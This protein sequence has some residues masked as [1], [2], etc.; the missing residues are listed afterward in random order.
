MPGQLSRLFT[1]WFLFAEQK[2]YVK[3]SGSNNDSRDALVTNR[4]IFFSARLFVTFLAASLFF[5]SVFSTPLFSYNNLAPGAIWTTNADCG[6]ET[7]DVNHYPVGG[8]VWV[9]GNNFKPLTEFDWT[10]TGQPGH[11]SC[12]PGEIVASGKITTDEDGAFCFNAYTVRE[13]DCGEYTVDVGNK[14]DNYRVDKPENPAIQIKKYTNDEDADTITGLLI[15]VGQTVIWKYVITNIGDVELKDLVLNDDKL[16]AI[17]LPQTK[18]ESNSSIQ[19]TMT[20]IASPG[21]YENTAT[22][23][24]KYRS[25]TVQDTDPSHYFGTQT[26]IDIEKATNGQDADEAPGPSLLTGSTVTWTYVVTNTGNVPLSNISVTDDQGVTVSIPKTTLQPGES[27]TGTAA[28]TAVAG[29]YKNIGVVTGSDGVQTV[30]DQDPS[31]YFG[32]Q[33]SIVIEKA[34]NG[35]DANEAPGPVLPVGSTVTWTYLLT[36]TGAVPLTNISV[37]DDQ[38]VVV[39]IPATTLQPGESMCGTATGIATAGQ[40][41]NIG[42]VVG[43]NADHMVTDQDPSHYFGSQ[44][45]IDIE[46]ATNGQDADEAPGPEISVGEDVHW[47]YVVT[48]TGN[49]TLTGITVTDDQ[50]EQVTLPK[51]TLDPGE[52]MVGT[53]DGKAKLGAYK[54][55]GLAVGHY[56]NQ[57]VTDQDPSHYTGVQKS[58]KSSVT[59]TVYKD[60]NVNGKKDEGESGLAGVVILLKGPEGMD[61]QKKTGGQ[62]SVSFH[63]LI[64]GIYTVT[65]VVENGTPN[66]QT[67]ELDCNAKRIAIGVTKTTFGCETIYYAYDPSP[68]FRIDSPLVECSEM[69]CPHTQEQHNLQ[70]IILDS[71]AFII[72][73]RTAADTIVADENLR[74]TKHL[75]ALGG[76]HKMIVML[77][78]SN[79]TQDPDLILRVQYLRRL[80]SRECNCPLHRCETRVHLYSDNDVLLFHRFLV[81]LGRPYLPADMIYSYNWSAKTLAADMSGFTDAYGYPWSR[82]AGIVFTQDVETNI[83]LLMKYLEDFVASGVPRI[84]TVFTLSDINATTEQRIAFF[85]QT[86]K[87][88]RRHRT[89]ILLFW[90][91]N[92]YK[93]TNYEGPTVLGESTNL[94]Q[95]MVPD[96]TLFELSHDLL[97]TDIRYNSIAID[98]TRLVL[99]ARHLNADSSKVNY[100][101]M[102]LLAKDYDLAYQVLQNAIDEV[103]EDIEYPL[104]FTGQGSPCWKEQD[105]SNAVDGDLEGWDGTVTTHGQEPMQGYQDAAWAVFSLPASVPFNSVAIQTDNG[106]HNAYTPNRWATQLEI[107]VSDDGTSFTSIG[108]MQRAYRTEGELKWYALPE[109][110]T[111]QFVKLVIYAPNRTNQAWRQLV[112]F[113]VKL[114]KSVPLTKLVNSFNPEI[115]TDEPAQFTLEQNHPNPF[116][117]ATRIAFQIPYDTVGRIIVFDLLGRVVRVLADGPFSAGCHVVSWDGQDQNNKTVATGMYMYRL[118]TDHFTTCRK[119]LI[120]R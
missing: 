67:F 6:D 106:I 84:N 107:F 12:D 62:G 30:S 120:L 75:C 21:Q 2:P 45:A 90:G 108:K 68:V 8:V 95:D 78:I 119:L 105:W 88:A 33:A 52:S 48:N 112:E 10:I 25:D 66:P 54:N 9:N 99:Q 39:A 27:M 26:S 47:T 49:V 18:L 11:A 82:S 20:G 97:C 13:D 69:P 63:N 98:L 93:S 7:Q 31:H 42:T 70:A 89:D 110:T 96:T 3:T 118:Q 23:T 60:N 56:G 19:V 71:K 22:V 4:C 41:K 116:N 86:W 109:K 64:P 29:Q 79:G 15:P 65:A 102:L 117:S 59:V 35:Q 57:Q 72:L 61:N 16:G 44:A 46:K 73:L 43:Y 101:I 76:D 38:G 81:E 58:C 92:F 14:N 114:I 77:D 28:G 100:G 50:G 104:Q 37:I 80:L 113:K 24:G 111:A 36:N 32:S 74:Q 51:T 34:T 83:N 103:T 1:L 40:Y 53:A 5:L 115:E 87:F 17:S 85:L 55:I 94:F 91:F